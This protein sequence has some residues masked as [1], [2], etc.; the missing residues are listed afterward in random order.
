M[1][2]FGEPQGQKA[3]KWSEFPYEGPKLGEIPGFYKIKET[4]D[5]ERLMLSHSAIHREEE[6]LE[7]YEY[8]KELC[9]ISQDLALVHNKTGTRDVSAGED[10]EVFDAAREKRDLQERKLAVIIEL[11]R[12]LRQEAAEYMRTRKR[13][14][15]MV[16]TEGIAVAS[17][18]MDLVVATGQA[19]ESDVFGKAEKKMNDK[20][21]EERL[22]S[23]S[24]IAAQIMKDSKSGLKN[25]K[26]QDGGAS[27]LRSKCRRARGWDEKRAGGNPW[28]GGG[29]SGGVG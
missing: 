28:E 14:A 16:G 15:R 29:W 19:D 7:A 18:I 8:C 6:Y 26:A 3:F 11:R 10:Q 21:L 22:K 17:W 25:G 27:A 12:V 2:I 23:M 9:G 13:F 1:D 5:S 4:V 20:I 24:K